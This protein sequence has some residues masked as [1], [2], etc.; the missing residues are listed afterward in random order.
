VSVQAGS[1]SAIGGSVV[2]AGL[3]WGLARFGRR[4]VAA[5]RHIAPARLC[6][7][8]PKSVRRRS[9]HPRRLRFVVS[10]EPA[11]V[12][13]IRDRAAD[14]ARAMPFAAD[15]IEDIRL[16]VG[17]AAANAVRHGRNSRWPKIGAEFRRSGDTLRVAVWDRGRGFDPG[18]QC[19]TPDCLAS[20]GRGV[21]LMKSLMDDVTFRFTRPGTR[22]E[23][24]KTAGRP[25]KSE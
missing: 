15:E 9:A 4:I 1:L 10:C 13:Q 7:R 5:L 25:K 19:Q 21:F 16:V 23:M 3:K 17:E 22:V 14:F 8:R 11:M 6:M 18:L 2:R 20:D 24:T 12:R